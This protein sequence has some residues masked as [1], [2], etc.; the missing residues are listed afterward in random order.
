MCFLGAVAGIELAAFAL[1]LSLLHTLQIT[2]I[3]KAPP[4]TEQAVQEHEYAEHV[5]KC[6][7]QLYSAEGAHIHDKAANDEIKNAHD[8]VH[9]S[10]EAYHGRA[11]A[12]FFV[13][14][15][16]VFFWWCKNNLYCLKAFAVRHC[17][18]K[19]A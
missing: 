15:H 3:Y 7:R 11:L 13:I 4:Y 16:C 18:M 14:I 1:A 9:G 17:K 2:K 19:I 12:S 10:P 5:G 6:L 8:D